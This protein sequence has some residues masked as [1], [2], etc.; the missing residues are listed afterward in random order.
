MP[1]SDDEDEDPLDEAIRHIGDQAWSALREAIGLR[2]VLGNVL[3]E[4]QRQGL[5]DAA[6]LMARL[7][8]FAES[9]P[10]RFE[11]DARVELT[12]DLAEALRRRPPEGPGTSGAAPPGTVFH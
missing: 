3:L 7:L 9:E 10:R 12:R 4:W 8:A 11:S 1:G 5:Y 2:F 6:P